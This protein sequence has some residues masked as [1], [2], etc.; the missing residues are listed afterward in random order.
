M[1]TLLVNLEQERRDLTEPQP[2]SRSAKRPA[3]LYLWLQVASD[4]SV[5][6]KR[7]PKRWTRLLADT[8]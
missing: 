8:A 1:K 2:S 3:K 5:E 7:G 4:K 6:L